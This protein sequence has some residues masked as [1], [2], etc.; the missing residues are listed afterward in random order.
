[1]TFKKC[2]E[3]IISKTIDE[4]NQKDLKLK[5]SKIVKD[6]KQALAIAL[7]TAQT[8]CKYTKTEITELTDKIDI[9]L[10]NKDKIS[11]SNVVQTKEII[12]NYVDKKNYKKA[13]TYLLLLINR[14][15]EN[16]DELNNNIIKQFN[17]LKKD[18][19]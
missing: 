7:N 14:V 9:F 17:N 4:F 19:L 15:F 1:M 16:K 13:Y 12:T 18:T 10:Q 5:N 2:S 11:L 3:E 8:K 6:K